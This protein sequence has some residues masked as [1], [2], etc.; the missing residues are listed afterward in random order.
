MRARDSF[1]GDVIRATGTLG[2][3]CATFALHV[4]MLG[5]KSNVAT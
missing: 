1:R 5:V 3:K 4:R 2:R